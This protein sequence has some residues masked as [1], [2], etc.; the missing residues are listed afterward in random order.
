[1]LKLLKRRRKGWVPEIGA[2]RDGGWIPEI[3]ADRANASRFLRLCC[4]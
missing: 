3:V 4:M 1:V 2:K